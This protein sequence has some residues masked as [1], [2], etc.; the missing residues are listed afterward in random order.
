MVQRFNELTKGTHAATVVLTPFDLIGQGEGAPGA[1]RA[2]TSISAPTSASSAPR[3][4]RG[5]R[6]T[7]LVGFIRAY[8]QGVQFLYDPANREVAEALLV[9]N[10]RAMT[11]ALAK[12]S[13]TVLLGDKNGF[14][15]DVRLDQ[16]GAQTVLALRSKYA[17]PKKALSDPGKYVAAV[18]RE[19]ALAR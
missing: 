10:V 9:A 14:Y 4:A 16:Q 6:T 11:P 2:P 12:Q 19:K 8:H 18:Y 7:A 13:L 5:P 3:G 17:E 15:K 1:S